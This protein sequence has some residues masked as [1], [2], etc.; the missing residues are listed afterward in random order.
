M[1]RVT[2]IATLVTE[3]RKGFAS[4]DEPFVST[5][6]RPTYA[7]L[8]IWVGDVIKAQ[9]GKAGDSARLGRRLSDVILPAKRGSYILTAALS[10]FFSTGYVII[11][12]HVRPIIV[13]A[14]IFQHRTAYWPVREASSSQANDNCKPFSSGLY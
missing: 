3:E 5:V 13:R 1:R 8:Q 14:S 7:L 11:Q 12:R 2:D 4:R 9:D 10:F 6:A